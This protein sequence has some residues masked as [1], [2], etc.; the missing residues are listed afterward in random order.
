MATCS[1]AVSLLLAFMASHKELGFEVRKTER[2]LTFIIAYI[3]L[4]MTLGISY[5]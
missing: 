3:L 5:K 1:S 4:E 2:K